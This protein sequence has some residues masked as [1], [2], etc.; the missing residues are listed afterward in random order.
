MLLVLLSLVV[1]DP[2]QVLLELAISSDAPGDS[3]LDVEALGG[4]VHLL[5]DKLNAALVDFTKFP[6]L[7]VLLLKD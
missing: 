7:V 3:L 2:A 4:Q 6:R 1:L 5:L